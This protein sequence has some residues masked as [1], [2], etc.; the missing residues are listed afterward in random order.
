[1]LAGC[2]AVII[3]QYAVRK[4]WLARGLLV[5]FPILA[6]AVAF[7]I[8]GG[9]ERAVDRA[10][11]RTSGASTPLRIAF[12]P[13]ALNTVHSDP[14]KP[15]DKIRVQIPVEIS[16]VADGYVVQVDD[17][18]FSL[19]SP[20]GAQWD[21]P[22]QGIFGERYFPG[23]QPISVPVVLSPAIFNQFKSKI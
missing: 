23:V 14:A 19:T 4:V 21:S 15:G 10:Y 20:D 16:D 6:G 1:M 13:D 12:A 18:K 5:A 9:D 11:P 8:T 7:A 2:G 22:W 17:V 3:I